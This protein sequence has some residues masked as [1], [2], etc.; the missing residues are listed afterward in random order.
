[1]TNRGKDILKA[2]ELLKAGKNV[3]IPTETVYGLAGNAYHLEAVLQIFSIKNRPKFDPLIVHTHS[4]ASVSE[5]VA[6]FPECSKRLLEA[7]SPGPLTVVL[8][9]KE[10]IDDLV[11]SGLPNVAVRIPNHSLT[12]ELLKALPF[13]LAAPSANPFTYVSPTSAQHVLDQLGDKIDY[14]LDGGDCEVGIES[15]IVREFPEYL[16]VLRLGGISLEDLEKVSSKPVKILA[17]NE[18]G[19]SPGNFKK[20]YATRT[21]LYLGLE[22][23]ENSLEVEKTAYIRFQNYL[24]DVPENQQILLAKD[25]STYTAARNLFSSLRWM[26]EQGYARIIAEKLPEVGLGKAV[27]D[28]LLRASR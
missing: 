10:V 26:D 5:F 8:P 2:A 28:R 4:I 7:F 25:G 6:D 17:G 24:S 21:P 14:V 27:N 9:K 11:T 12:L 13:P 18:V 15:T 20:H 3:A 23:S 16:A 1:M 22:N 19:S